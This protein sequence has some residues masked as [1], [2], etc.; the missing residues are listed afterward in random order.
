[1]HA[2]APGDVDVA[3]PEAEVRQVL[4]QDLLDIGIDPR[5]SHIIELGRA[6]LDQPVDRGVG[7]AAAV[8]PQG[9]DIA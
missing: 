6:G 3:V 9:W 2:V 5:P 7:V 8:E 4:C 1:M